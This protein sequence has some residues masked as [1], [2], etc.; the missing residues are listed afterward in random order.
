MKLHAFFTFFLLF[1]INETS[2]QTEAIDGF[3]DCIIYK[4]GSRI[5]GKIVYYVPTDTLTFQLQSGQIMRCPPAIIK[6]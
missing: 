6:W 3:A 4:N 2:A 1:L 5:Y